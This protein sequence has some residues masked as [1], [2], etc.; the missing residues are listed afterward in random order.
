MLSVQYALGLASQQHVVHMGN[1][2]VSLTVH[3]I[4]P[5]FLGYLGSS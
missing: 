2:P 1:I 4:S 5:S 3:T